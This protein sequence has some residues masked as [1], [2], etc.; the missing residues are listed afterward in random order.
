MF[1]ILMLMNGWTSRQVRFVL[2]YP[3]ADIEC[4]MFVEVPQG[5][6]MDGVRT[7]H[8]LRLQKNLYGQKQAESVFT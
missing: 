8:C 1:L 2:A 5:F 6:N 3:Q 7:D 4:E